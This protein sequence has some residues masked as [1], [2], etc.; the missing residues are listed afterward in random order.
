MRAYKT[1]EQSRNLSVTSY[2][3]KSQNSLRRRVDNVH[4]K[5]V[6]YKHMQF[7]LMDIYTKGSKQ[8]YYHL[9]I[10]MDCDN[11]KRKLHEESS[12]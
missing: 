8:N 2:F 3:P 1:L 12:K 10:D 5:Y 7:C 4:L 6:S 11:N 9:Y